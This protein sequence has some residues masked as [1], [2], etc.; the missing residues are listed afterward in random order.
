MSAFLVGLILV[1][2]T[3]SNEDLLNQAETAFA[4]GLRLREAGE[5]GGTSFRQAAQAY[6]QLRSRGVRNPLIDRNLGNAYY[7]AGDLPQAILAYRRG[8]RRAPADPVLRD[9]LEQA[10]AQVN[11][12]EGSSTGRPRP[13]SRPGWLVALGPGWLFFLFTLTYSAGWICLVRWWMVRQGRFLAAGVGLLVL[14]A[15]TGWLLGDRPWRQEG[16]LVVAR[17]GVLLR[18]GNGR[19][20][21]VWTDTPI[22]RG[23]EAR[24][25]FRRDDWLQIELAGGEIGW[26]HAADVIEDTDSTA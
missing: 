5:R 18:K 22:N 6:E 4:H 19:S 7:L 10:R 25:L 3:L 15:A 2:G 1:A 24:L 20:F 26:V 13:S 21:P 8:L 11:F 23:V 16:T 12:A 9:H 17:D 14:A